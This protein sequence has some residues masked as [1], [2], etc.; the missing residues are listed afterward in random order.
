MRIMM[1]QAQN[2]RTMMR[3]NSMSTKIV[4]VASGK[5]GVGKSSLALNLGIAL[6]RRGRKPLIID[7]DFGFSNIDVMLGIHT[8]HDLLDVIEGRRSVREVIETGLEGVQFISGGSGVYELLRMAP[9]QLM[10]IVDGLTELEDVADTI[11]FDTS[12]GLSEHAMRL[13]R[14]SHETILV[15]TP[16]PTS[17]VDAY[18][19][20]K[21]MHDQGERPHISLVVNKAAGAKEAATVAE[22]FARIAEKN[23]C[24]RINSLGHVTRDASMSNA[25][26]MQVPILISYPKCAASSDIY[27]LTQRYL[28]QPPKA[29]KRPGVAGFL[30]YFLS[31]NNAVRES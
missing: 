5:G 31:R 1:D 10:G 17:V 8:Q 18:A 27:S 24:V 28:G 23:L 26:K 2:L 7:T 15:T 6:S 25:V 30:E 20:L 19:L 16:E 21:I 4:T 11:I 3:L 13:I 9:D 22:G 14:A 12:A 29:T